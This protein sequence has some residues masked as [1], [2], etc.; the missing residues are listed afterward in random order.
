[1][2]I[3]RARVRPGDSTVAH[4]LSGV[5]ERYLILEGEGEVTVGKSQP[6][7]VEAG[8]MVVIPADVP[9]AIVNTGSGDLVFLCICTPRFRWEVYR[10]LDNGIDPGPSGGAAIPDT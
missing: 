9:Q 3:A 8:D 6:R 7:S 4:S 10:R 5:I 1:M 2:S